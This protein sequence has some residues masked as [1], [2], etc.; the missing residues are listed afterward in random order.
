ME[1]DDFEIRDYLMSNCLS[2]S[3]D[4]E[5]GLLVRYNRHRTQMEKL[6][7]EIK[8]DIVFLLKRIVSFIHRFYQVPIKN[9][10]YTL[11]FPK[12]FVHTYV[13][14]DDG[15]GN[16][17]LCDVTTIVYTESAQE[18]VPDIIIWGKPVIYEYRGQ[19]YQAGGTT[20]WGGKYDDLNL[21]SLLIIRGVLL[22]IFFECP[23]ER[24]IKL[25][26]RNNY[27]NSQER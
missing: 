22:N 8:L 12:G 21:E 10:W 4:E 14:M 7:K 24:L 26:Q 18:S 13:P 9:N 5:K 15:C 19:E 3:E 23:P 6:D 11:S 1:I 2:I 27:A 20:R 25:I 17:A 16:L